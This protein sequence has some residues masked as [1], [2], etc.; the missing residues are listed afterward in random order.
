MFAG[1]RSF[2]DF[3]PIRGRFLAFLGDDFH[4]VAGG[5]FDVEWFV[6]VIDFGFNGFVA[7]VGMDFI[8]KI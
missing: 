8:G 1:V 6:G 3:Q 7:N 4:D 2:D 5:E